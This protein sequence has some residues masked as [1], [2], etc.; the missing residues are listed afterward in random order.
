MQDLG[1]AVTTNVRGNAKGSPTVGLGPGWPEAAQ[2]N[3]PTLPTAAPH[4][5]VAV[6]SG[7]ATQIAKI[8]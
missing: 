5:S 2:V 6:C 7:L 3:D 1:R 4:R 8:R